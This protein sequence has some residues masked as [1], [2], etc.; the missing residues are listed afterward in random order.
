MDREHIVKLREGI[1]MKKIRGLTILLLLLV[2]SSFAFASVLPAQNG[3]VTDSAGL[4]TASERVDIE[5]ALSGFDY[6]VVVL[7][8]SGLSESEGESLAWEAYDGW[9]LTRDQ[10]LLVITVDPNYVHL[11][12]DNIELKNKISQS[13]VR[14]PQ[15]VVDEAFV[16]LAMQ[17]QIA[18]GVKKVGAFLNAI[19][20]ESVST[21]SIPAPAQPSTPPVVSGNTN[22]S[23]NSSSAS[24]DADATPFLVMVATIIV[25]V[26]F[27]IVLKR[28]VSRKRLL[29]RLSTAKSNLKQAMV[30]LNKMMVSEMFKELEMGF[31]QGRTKDV[32]G[33]L[34]RA[35]HALH[36]RTAQLD[37][38]LLLQK[39]SLRALAKAEDTISSYEKAIAAF[40]QE[41]NDYLEQF[42][43]LET[44]TVDVR[45]TVEQ[46]K[47]RAVHVSEQVEALATSTG[48]TLQTMRA[49]LTEAMEVL[50]AADMHDEFDIL[51]AEEEITRA[52]A[53]FDQLN[54]GIE[55]IRILGKKKTELEP[56]IEETE[57]T[58]RSTVARERLLLVDADPFQTLTEAHAILPRLDILLDEGDS[59]VL[60]E[61]IARV[62][63]LVTA[64]TESVERMITD[65]NQAS[66]T[67]RTGEALS[68][69]L[70]PVLEQRAGELQRLQSHY[71]SHHVQEQQER[72]KELGNGYEE[73]R[74][75]LTHIRAD[76]D[77]NV[78]RY[79]D[80]F[81]KSVTAE[82][83]M[84]Q[85]RTVR[86]QITSYYRD[87]EA[88]RQHATN[89]ERVW[90][91]HFQ[92]ALHTLTQLQL[93]QHPLTSQISTAEG[94]L[95]A[96]RTSLQHIPY[97]VAQM[98]TALYDAIP[99]VEAFMRAVHR[100]VKE[101]QE[102]EREFREFQEAYNR[103][104]NRYGTRV[105]MGNYNNSYNRVREQVTQMIAAG[106]FV[107][108]MKQLTSGRDLI[109]QMEADYNRAV[110]EEQRRRN[111]G[112]PP[113]MGGG[114]G[115]RSSGSSGWGGSSGRS[116]GSSS[117]GGS[118][119]RSSGSSSWG[120]SSGRSSGSSKW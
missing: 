65:R 21:P 50:T 44:K 61:Q 94:A 62:H 16:P 66:T 46:M 11:V 118:S 4:F 77:P 116:S 64:A 92:Q 29:A 55:Q 31:Y 6:E 49:E 73:L 10:V 79:A 60:L 82:T 59:R 71:A 30:S 83:L 101:K 39:V 76:S 107:E 111:S 69:E 85:L 15:G 25:F 5:A 17:G 35:V 105:R 88:K 93:Q 78:Q 32:V 24:K 9:G 51:L 3:N 114:G 2:M 115:G 84:N 117:W 106:L 87:L 89:E 110:R 27:I 100:L 45:R 108:A 81:A 70:I 47:E 63:T 19:A 36:E 112:G 28:I 48:Y 18:E 41:S 22:A 1:A 33:T 53:L 75:L 95:V 91:G 8:A 68:A 98:E 57:R 96:L 120:G 103:S 86:E 14:D 104:Y 90:E 119:G 12:F 20:A 43:V 80:A 38:E 13:F 26:L 67:I 54:E 23:T 34:E 40:T 109:R 99:A 42:T 113:R 74:T 52:I 97:D 58:L 7:T 102:A 56:L 72:Y 37:S